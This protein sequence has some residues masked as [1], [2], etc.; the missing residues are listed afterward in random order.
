M[1]PSPSETGGTPIPRIGRVVP[2]YT[3]PVIDERAVRAAARILLL[4]GGAAF[5]TAVFTGTT[6]PLQPFGMYFMIDMLLRVTAGDRWSPTLFL[7][8]LAVRRQPP[9]W[10]GAPQKEFAWW[11]GFGLALA[12]CASMGLFAAPFQLTLA[13]CGLCLLLLFLETA[14]GICVGCAL[15][16]RFGGRPPRYCAGGS[17]GIAGDEPRST[18]PHAEMPH[19]AAHGGPAPR[20]AAPRTTPRSAG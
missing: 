5:A 20:P 9:E 16:S 7:G 12:A 13:L 10:V 8:R 18:A 15:Q 17:C 1:S 11:L 6:R 3:I 14:F 19:A 4:L 2:G